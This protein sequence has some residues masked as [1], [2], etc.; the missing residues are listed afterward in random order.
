LSTAQTTP[1]ETRLVFWRTV[2]L[3]TVLAESSI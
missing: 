3:I 1:R 2:G